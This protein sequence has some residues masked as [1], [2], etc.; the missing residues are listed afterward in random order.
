M[1]YFQAK[2]S[3]HARSKLVLSKR[4]IDKS[5]PARKKNAYISH[6]SRVDQ[7]NLQTGK[8]K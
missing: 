8:T 5:G 4:A 1:F 7:G 6:G 2:P 3:N